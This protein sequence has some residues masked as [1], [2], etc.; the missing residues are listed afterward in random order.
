M[1]LIYI[2]IAIIALVRALRVAAAEAR[3]KRD[4]ANAELAR[5]RMAERKAAKGRS[6]LEQASVENV[7]WRN[8]DAVREMRSYN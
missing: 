5:R 6:A 3:M 7:G 2:L 4:K 1:A 8:V